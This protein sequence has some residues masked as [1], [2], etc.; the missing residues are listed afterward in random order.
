MPS[1]GD[2]LKSRATLLALT[3]LYFGG[4]AVLN[5]RVRQA[6]THPNCVHGWY[7]KYTIAE[8]VTY[9]VWAVGFPVI[10]AFLTARSASRRAPPASSNQVPPA[11][12]DPRKVPRSSARARKSWDC[13][14]CHRT[15]HAG[16]TYW[17]YESGYGRDT[18]RHR[19]CSR[20]CSEL[21]SG[22]FR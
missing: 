4:C 15:I 22:W 20:C 8:Q 2:S 16:Q 9:I 12:W 6:C 19:I 13:E 5:A 11:I 18:S 1:G 3:L 17:Y 10:A 21:P 14:R 7:S